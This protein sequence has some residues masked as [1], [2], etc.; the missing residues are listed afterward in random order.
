M[1]YDLTG[2]FELSGGK[3]RP[4][5]TDPCG[6]AAIVGC[7]E[8]KGSGLY[9]PKVTDVGSCTPDSGC[10]KLVSGKYKPVLTFDGYDTLEGLTA[11][12][13]APACQF[14]TGATP[15]Y[16]QVTLSDVEP[17]FNVCF[18]FWYTIPS[19][20][21]V[22]GIHILEQVTGHPCAWQSTI[23]GTLTVREYSDSNCTMFYQETEGN[24]DLLIQMTTAGDFD[25]SIRW[26]RFSIAH[27]YG[28]C[29]E[30][31]CVI[32]N[33]TNSVTVCKNFEM[34]KDGTASVDFDYV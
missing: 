8:D 29:P 33:I 27:F 14:C 34:Y 2:C 19:A 24:I 23:I 17:C 15:K 3:Y 11:A 9:G 30:C 21:A 5:W 10:V 31:S 1:S 32:S 20:V 26:D 7:M 6:G 28:T 13:C 4:K 22:N 12:C 25:L 16:I 18:N